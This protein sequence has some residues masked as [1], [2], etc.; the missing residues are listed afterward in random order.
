MSGLTAQWRKRGYELG[1]GCGVATGYATLGRIGF[2]GRYDYG[3][4][5]AKVAP[6]LLREVRANTRLWIGIGADVVPYVL[7]VNAR[8]GK[9]GVIEGQLP[10]AELK[11]RLGLP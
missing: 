2:E 7:Y 11:R 1:F 9:A 8:D 6:A 4:M 3:A 10:T 5:P